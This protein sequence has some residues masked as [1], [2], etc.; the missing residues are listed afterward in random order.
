MTDTSF[1]GQSSSS[2]VCAFWSC[3]LPVRTFTRDCCQLLISVQA[4][5]TSPNKWIKYALLV[6]T[7]GFTVCWHPINA[8]WLSLNQPS[9]QHRAIAMAM[10]I[11]SAN[12]GAVIG[13]QMMRKSDAPLY[14]IGFRACIA[15]VAFGNVVAIGQHLQYRWSNRR[16]ERKTR[17][18]DGKSLFVYTT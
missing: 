12:T 11:M 10:F 1:E 13:S 4:K 9:P 6:L 14:R 18:E 7:Y 5:S 15:L 17:E 8:T 3:G 2:R 16:N